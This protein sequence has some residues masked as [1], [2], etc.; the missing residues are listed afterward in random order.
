MLR[1]CFLSPRH[2]QAQLS[3]LG[4]TRQRH[5]SLCLQRLLP[6]RLLLMCVSLHQCHSLMPLLRLTPP[7]H[8]HLTFLQPHSQSQS[9]CVVLLFR[10]DL[11]LQNCHLQLQV[12][13]SL[14]P[15][16]F[17]NNY[18]QAN[19]QKSSRTLPSLCSMNVYFSRLGMDFV[20]VSLQYTS[21]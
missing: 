7:L 14:H 2:L 17:P 15:I 12:K 20:L 10:S 8:Q 18:H 1:L 16:G 9:P 13:K 19:G 21:V 4:F 11:N 6:F 5:L 3:L